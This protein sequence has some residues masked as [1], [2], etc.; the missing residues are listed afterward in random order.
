[1]A[2]QS[3]G[4]QKGFR[5]TAVL[6]A[7][8]LAIAVLV[9]VAQ[10]KSIWSTTTGSHGQPVPALVDRPGHGGHLVAAPGHV[11][12][13]RSQFVERRRAYLQAIRARKGA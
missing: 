9:L 7:L 8:A 13:T 6:V 1:M 4:R 11:G 5:M 2:P 3:V 12:Q 10:A